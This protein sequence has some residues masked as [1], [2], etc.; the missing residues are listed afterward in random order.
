MDQVSIKYTDIF[1][2]KTLQNLPKFGFLVW[3]QTIWQPCWVVAF[4]TGPTFGWR[5]SLK[6]SC[7]RNNWFVGR[8][9]ERGATL[10]RRLQTCRQKS[11]RLQTYRNISTNM[12][13]K[14]RRLQTC[15]QKSRRLSNCRLL[16]VSHI[17][18]SQFIGRLHQFISSQLTDMSIGRLNRLSIL[19]YRHWP[20][21]NLT[22]QL[23]T[24]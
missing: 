14:I 11:R 22:K 18:N 7:L 21:P 13:T 16:A 19:L 8:R 9:H 6:K 24:T 23:A 15:R 5:H 20:W 3:K 10:F 4:V 2:I 12:S 1:H 17:V